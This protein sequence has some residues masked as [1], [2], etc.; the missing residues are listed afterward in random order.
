MPVSKN[1][2]ALACMAEKMM[3]GEMKHTY[4]EQAHK[5]MQSMSKEKLH[6]WCHSTDEEMMAEKKEPMMEK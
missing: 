5:M 2:R 1:Q 6:E 4:S 3:D